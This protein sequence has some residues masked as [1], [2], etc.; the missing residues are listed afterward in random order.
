MEEM[1]KMEREYLLTYFKDGNA[2]YEWF[3]DIDEMQEFIDTNKIDGIFE[4]LQI[5]GTNDV[6][7]QLNLEDVK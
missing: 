5:R 1:S 7:D 6:E 4:T 2:K 3:E